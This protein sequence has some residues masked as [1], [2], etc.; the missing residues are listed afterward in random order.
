M[1]QAFVQI[2]YK[3]DGPNVIDGPYLMSTS[4][5]ESRQTTGPALS[6]SLGRMRPYRAVI[7]RSCNR[8][9]AATWIPVQDCLSPNGDSRRGHDKLET[10]TSDY[11]QLRRFQDGLV[12]N[13]HRLK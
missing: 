9:L 13:S 8:A 7:E 12:G 11:M 3:D 5:I 10:S 4:L 2:C 1:L 6:D